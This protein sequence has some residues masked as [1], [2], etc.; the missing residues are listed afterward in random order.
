M[1]RRVFTVFLVLPIYTVLDNMYAPMLNMLKKEFEKVAALHLQ[2]RQQ[3]VTLKT[4]RE[5]LEAEIR[6]VMEV[7]LVLDIQIQALR[8]AEWQANHPLRDFSTQIRDF[9]L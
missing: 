6:R 5:T 1:K 7:K 8:E 2:L 4:S 3:E 9:Q